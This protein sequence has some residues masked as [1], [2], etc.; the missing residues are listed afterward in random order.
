M[1]G[2]P[3]GTTGAM[4][5]SAVSLLREDPELGKGLAPADLAAAR[6]TLIA[7]AVKLEP[8]PWDWADEGPRDGPPTASM[9][10]LEGL[11]LSEIVL[12]GCPSAELIGPGDVLPPPAR[13][14][15]ADTL[16]PVDVTL[17]VLEPARVALLDERFQLACAH[18]PP[19]ALA[20]F[21]RM[22][23]RGW[24]LAKQA[25]ICHLPAVHSRLLAL[26]WHLA[27]RWGKVTPDHLLLP[28]RILHRTLGEMVGAERSTVSLALRQ[29]SDA[30]L[31]TRRPDGAWLL[32]GDPS[33]GLELLTDR[34]CPRPASFV[35]TGAADRAQVRFQR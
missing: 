31:V 5:Q 34:C 29:L 3:G 28:L 33:T 32:S 4:T 22:E 30:G 13:S 24:R 14:R 2:E 19:V 20:L 9:L 12:A 26:F 23:Q 15:N 1:R 6:R 17:T 27:D 18:W 35:G 8:G 7:P 11:L 25:A 16:L 10:V 21:E